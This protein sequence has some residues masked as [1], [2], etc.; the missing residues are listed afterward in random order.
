MTLY[1]VANSYPAILSQNGVGLNGGKVY[2]GIAGQDPEVSPANVYW[3]GAGTILAAQPLDVVGG[4]I[5]RA[6]T[7]ATAYIS[8]LTYS[9]RVRDRFGVEVYYSAE[10]NDPV[11][12]LEA[13]LDA[14]KANTDLDNLTAGITGIDANY[15]GSGN[16]AVLHSK[17]MNFA[18]A[19]AAAGSDVANVTF[20]RQANYTG[21]TVGFTNNALRAYTSVASGV[22]AFEWT[23]LSVME[24]SA[25]AGE[26]V[27]IYGQGQKKSTGATWASTFEAIDTTG[28]ANPSTGL[29]GSEVDIRANGTDNNNSRVGVD[30]VITRQLVAGVPTGAAME[31]G[32][33]VR[34]QNGSDGSASVKIGYGFY[35]G[36]TVVTGFDSSIAN[37]TGDAVKLATNQTIAFDVTSQH[38]LSYDG[39]G[40]AYKA[41]GTLQ[42]RLNANGSFQSRALTFATLPTPGTAGNRAFITDCNTTTFNAVAAGGGGNK[43]P[44][45]DDGAAWRVG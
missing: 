29:V 36:T 15:Q 10:V 44:V 43:V 37:I 41:A 9:I 7:P 28:T 22:T 31:A 12:V 26:N 45:F 14:A 2:I 40:L 27:A 33:G 11:A 42:S 17:N 1:S 5:Q 4:Y 16:A 13:S 38:R 24:N 21:G 19:A 32:W 6:G 30:V 3:D 20:L 35:T 23:L 18:T 8:A 39:G 34:I 25:A